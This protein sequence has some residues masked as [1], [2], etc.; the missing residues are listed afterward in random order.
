MRE[1]EMMRKYN[2]DHKKAHDLL[3]EEFVKD[4]ISTPTTASSSSTKSTYKSP[5]NEAY[6]AKI[7]KIV[8]N[9]RV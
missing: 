6:R 1:V 9:M 4:F 3:K 5:L 8:K 2:Y 7:D